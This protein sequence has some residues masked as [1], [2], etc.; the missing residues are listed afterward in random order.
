MNMHIPELLWN[1]KLENGQTLA[2]F[3]GGNP[4]SRLPLTNLNSFTE[5]WSNRLADAQN[6]NRKDLE[7]RANSILQFLS[8]NS[9][10]ACLLMWPKHRISAL[11]VEHPEAFVLIDE[12]AS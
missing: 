8:M 11:F 3:V 1:L 4:P 7:V 5:I 10:G 6:C 12:T 9:Q 2:E